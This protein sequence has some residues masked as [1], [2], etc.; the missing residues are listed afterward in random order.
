MIQG[1][2]CVNLQNQSRSRLVGGPKEQLR[3]SYLKMSARYTVYL[4]ML[5]DE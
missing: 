4:V 2:G 5:A 1:Y 3:K